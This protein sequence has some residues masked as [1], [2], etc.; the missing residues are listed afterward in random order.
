MMITRG[1]FLGMAA[2]AI[3]LAG[4]TA[5]TPATACD[6]WTIDRALRAIEGR[7]REIER[8]AA[9]VGDVQYKIDHIRKAMKDIESAGRVRPDS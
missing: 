3:D 2:L 6:T 1:K 9:R 7:L 5:P 8:E 4:L